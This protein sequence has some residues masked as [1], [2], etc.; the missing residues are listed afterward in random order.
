MI[1]FVLT[2]YIYEQIVGIR[3]EQG[4]DQI[5]ARAKSLCSTGLS[6]QTVQ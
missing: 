6:N 1:P 5:G 3:S 2:N 4:R